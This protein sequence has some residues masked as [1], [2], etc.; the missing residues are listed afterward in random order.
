[1]REKMREHL[2]SPK[3]SGLDLKQCVGGI[4]D[5]EFMTQYWVLGF[6]STYPALTTYSD[7]LRILEA[8]ARAG[9]MTDA[10]AEMLQHS[11][12]QLRELY[13]HLTLADH[14]YAQSS[15]DLETLRQRVS[16]CWQGVFASDEGSL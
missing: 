16:A 12:L 8:V 10:Q 4:T 5:I 9:L 7:N 11:Y 15:D 1:M 3:S 6:A 14:R 13:H 2:L